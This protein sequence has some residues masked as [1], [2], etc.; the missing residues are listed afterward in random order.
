MKK[1]KFGSGGMPSMKESMESGNRVSRQVGAETKKLMPATRSTRPSVGDAIAS[2]NRMSKKNAE[3]LKAVKKYAKGG[4]VDS[5]ARALKIGGLE[6]KDGS[7]TATSD[8]SPEDKK[9]VE[10]LAQARRPLTSPSRPLREVAEAIIG[11]KAADVQKEI[12]SIYTASG[13]KKAAGGTTKAYAKGGSVSSR[14]D[15]IA[16]K[17][18]T[19]GKMV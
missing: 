19:K 6:K 5:I 18:K 2:G 13:Q 12:N 15:G 17:G 8:L 9:K 1:R 14:A 7:Y 16:K 11:R 10:K 4:V 3:D